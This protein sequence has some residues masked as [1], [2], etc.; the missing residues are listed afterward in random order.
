LDEL[1]LELAGPLGAD[2]KKAFPFRDVEDYY[3]RL[4]DGTLSVGGFR[5]AKEKGFVVAPPK[6]ERGAVRYNL[7]YVL[8]LSLFRLAESSRG[9]GS[10]EEVSA[11]KTLILYASPTRGGVDHPCNWVDEIDH[12]DPVMIHPKAAQGL[13]LSDG[14]WVTLTGPAGTITTRVRLTEGIHPE[15]V[16]MAATTLDRETEPPCLDEAALEQQSE[17]QQRWWEGESYGGNGR[18]VIP[19]PEKPHR[20]SPGWMDTR[21]TLTRLEKKTKG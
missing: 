17:G 15:A 20:E 19:W 10:N 14:D 11:E 8:S 1:L 13:G 7:K 21:V 3:R 4:L 2:G 12:A 9:K 16:A 5:E 18:E 6:A